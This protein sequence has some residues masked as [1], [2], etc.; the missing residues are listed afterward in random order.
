MAGD[1]SPRQRHDDRDDA[2]S[3]ANVGWAAVSYLI[4]GMAFWGFIGWLIDRWQ[5]T[6]GI[7]T[8]IGCVLGMAGGIFLVVRRLGA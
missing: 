1:H 4:A 8:A 6:G 3:G 7:A 5:H 2:A